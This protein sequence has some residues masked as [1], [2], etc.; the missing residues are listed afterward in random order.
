MKMD[1]FK[2]FLRERFRVKLSQ[3]D[4]GY[5][6]TLITGIAQKSSVD[7]RL[8]EDIFNQYSYLNALAVVDTADMMKFHLQ[9]ERFYNDCK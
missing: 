8:V 3:Q 7:K 5:D 1:L 9:L 2:A 6:D 4:D